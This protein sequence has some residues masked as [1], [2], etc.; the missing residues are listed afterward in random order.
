VS[1]SERRVYELLL[2]PEP[3]DSNVTTL[4]DLQKAWL[5]VRRQDGS[6]YDPRTTVLLDD[7]ADKALHQPLN[8]LCISEFTQEAA[9]EQRNHFFTNR[10]PPSPRQSK[11]EQ[12]YDNQREDLSP[13]YDKMLIAVVG[14][15][16]RLQHETNVANWIQAGGI[17]AGH[18]PL[19]PR[20]TSPDSATTEEAAAQPPGPGNDATISA[21]AAPPD[22]AP[23]LVQPMWFEH[24]E[25]FEHWV[26]QGKQAA[27]SMNFVL[28]PFSILAVEAMER[29]HHER[30]P[31]TGRSQPSTPGRR[32]HQQTR[33]YD[34]DVADVSED[35]RRSSSPISRTTVPTQSSSIDASTV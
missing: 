17:W 4:K 1:F 15:L 33:N 25:V 26:D 18:E 5:R 10:P 35:V 12:R 32:D 13:V 7:S 16:S 3:S 29:E 30:A 9:H 27:K 8:H 34:P 21:D 24:P 28:Q 14:I 11:Q 6:P 31:S 20:P 2:N 19:P 23:K 22:D